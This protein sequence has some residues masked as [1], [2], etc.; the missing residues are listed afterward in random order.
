MNILDEIIARKKTA[1]ADAVTT[2]P[3]SKLE[4]SPFFSRPVVSFR[5]A[6]G[7]PARKGIIA[8]FK[9]K[10]PSEGVINDKADLLQVTS[11]YTHAGA[12]ALSIL[13]DTAYFGGSNGDLEMARSHEQVALLRKEFIVDEYQ[14][15]EARA[16]GADA[17]LLI[18]AALTVKEVLLLSLRARSLGLEVLLELH[19][20]EEL[21]HLNPFVDVVGVNNRNLGTFS[22]A[23]QTSLDLFPALPAEM[24][25]ISE[26]GIHNPADV[27]LLK[28]AGYDGCLVGT[29]FMKQPDPGRAFRDFIK[30]C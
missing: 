15:F 3:V 18:A 22:T 10:S 29:A 13:T 14:V 12:S 19:T 11:A 8:E 5:D 20:E 24:F 17:I 2:V 28:D 25:K 4:Q 30:Q 21:G 27:K 1:V 23:L 16:I 6:I 7:D 9:R 26:S